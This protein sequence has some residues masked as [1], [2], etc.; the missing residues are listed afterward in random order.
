MEDI[1]Q[2]RNR[3]YETTLSGIHFI[4][5]MIAW[6]K[7]IDIPR[8]QDAFDV[9]FTCVQQ[10]IR[11]YGLQGL[12]YK[13]HYDKMFGEGAWDKGNK[14]GRVKQTSQKRN[15]AAVASGNS[16]NGNED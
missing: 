6:N 11:E 16:D 5:D 8:V 12:G 9:S 10:T 3:K 13:S 7:E 2:K 14:T 15:Y 4:K 1:K